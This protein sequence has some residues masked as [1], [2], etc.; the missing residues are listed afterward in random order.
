[1]RELAVVAFVNIFN[2]IG[3]CIDGFC[4]IKRIGSEQ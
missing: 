3:I 4:G 2:S 1:M